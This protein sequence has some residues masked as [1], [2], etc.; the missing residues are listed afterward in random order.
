MGRKSAALT[1]RSV[2][3]RLDG[4]KRPTAVSSA[5]LLC[6]LLV[7]A[8]ADPPRSPVLMAL[9][10]S[11][12]SSSLPELIKALGPEGRPK[13]LAAL[14]RLD[15]AALDAQ[16]LVE[17]RDAYR[18]LG[19]LD[20]KIDNDIARA[21]DEKTILTLAQ[22]GN[23]A[24]AQTAAETALK[25]YPDDR[26][27]LFLLH[28]AKGRVAPG[29]V[30]ASAGKRSEAAM[31]AS[32]DNRPFRLAIKPP[33]AHISVPEPDHSAE[34][35][36]YVPGGSHKLNMV[37]RAWNNAHILYALTFRGQNAKDTADM[38]R[39]TKA[40]DSTETGR[41]LVAELGGWSEIKKSVDL[42]MATLPGGM[43]G[44]TMPSNVGGRTVLLMSRNLMKQPD[45][46]TASV[47]AHELRHVADF[48]QGDQGPGLALPSEYAAHRVQVRTF[49]EISA[50]M[51]ESE[52]KTAAGGYTW[53]YSKFLADLWTDHI[54][55]RFP[56]KDQFKKRFGNKAVAGMAG[57]AY[58]DLDGSAVAP[59]SAHLDHHLNAPV[60]GLYTMLT[61]EKDIAKII[62]EKKKDGTPP[63]AVELS[64]LKR[65]TEMMTRM[66]KDDEDYRRV[67]SL[68]LEKK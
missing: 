57:D 6:V 29:A 63:T 12:T 21:G 46:V 58:S 33:K 17:L 23:F 18:L 32:P 3:I 61:D 50:G 62:L 28:Q 51:P 42:R 25:L 10:P 5:V 56:D 20:A 40:L 49:L 37:D 16:A 14:D 27:L 26:N 54:L 11:A 47:L 60:R 2:P 34:Q 65:R 43:G 67:H 59:G 45:A 13:A 30:P 35:L 36:R 64:A 53:E 66:D 1:A 4:L 68:G 38:A 9:A 7:V 8:R 19:R 15:R 48:K 22:A 31:P 24:A 41:A 44:V 39:M 52:K 55:A